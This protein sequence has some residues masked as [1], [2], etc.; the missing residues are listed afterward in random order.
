MHNLGAARLM[1]RGVAVPEHSLVVREAIGQ[2]NTD[3]LMCVSDYRPCCSKPR[4]NRWVHPNGN[5]VRGRKNNLFRATRGSG[6]VRLHHSEGATGEG[7]FSCEIRVA[8]DAIQTLYIGVYPSQ[9]DED[10]DG[11]SRYSTDDSRYST[12][13]SRYSTDDS[14]EDSTEDSTDDST[15]PGQGN[16]ALYGIYIKNGTYSKLCVASNSSVSL[17]YSIAGL[18][19]GKIIQ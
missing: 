11:E 12:D 16:G 6:V 5:T 19:H 4:E 2:S 7:M 10:T 17:F 13:N 15:G 18:L 14:T 3:T 9:P 1:F 8:D